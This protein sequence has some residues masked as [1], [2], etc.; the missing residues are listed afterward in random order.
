MLIMPHRVHSSLNLSNL[1]FLLL[2]DV[3]D[4]L[5]VCFGLQ[6]FL[7]FLLEAALQF[8]QTPTQFFVALLL[9]LLDVLAQL[10]DETLAI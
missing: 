9:Q 3:L 4:G 8:G 6:V 5:E 2:L 1:L 10:S 7:L